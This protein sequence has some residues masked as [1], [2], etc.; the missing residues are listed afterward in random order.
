MDITTPDKIRTI[1]ENAI[2][3]DGARRRYYAERAERSFES[4]CVVV[5]CVLALAVVLIGAACYRAGQDAGYAE[6]TAEAV[7][8]AK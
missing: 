2:E 5:L 1:R 7:E 8:E 6:A 3:N 4:A